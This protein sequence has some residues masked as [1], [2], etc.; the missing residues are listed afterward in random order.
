MSTM[1]WVWLTA[2]VVFLILELMTP[3]FVFACFVVGS[4]VAGAFGYFY[5]ESYYWQVG[6]FVL[7]TT[8]LLPLT[9]TLAK[10]ITKESPEKSNI[11]ALIGK[12]ALV[13]KAIDPDLGG[14]VKIEGEVWA[15]RAD[16]Q[17]SE[18]EK[19]R[20]VSISGTK[21]HVERLSDTKE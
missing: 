7:L 13:T 21:A 16:E 15:A 12:V 19:V 2:A 14:Q 4:V 9:R 1:F 6:I 3:T 20:V 18:N 17:I 11:D 10:K 5:P 8:V